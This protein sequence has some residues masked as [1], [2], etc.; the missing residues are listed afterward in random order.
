MNTHRTRIK[1]IC[2]LF[3][4][5]AMIIFRSPL[6]I[7]GIFVVVT[8]ISIIR[9]SRIQVKTRLLSLGV[10][11]ASVIIFQVVCNGSVSMQERLLLGSESALRI[12]T[13]SL[14]VFLFTETTSV[15]EI[16]SA[17]SFLPQKMRLMMTIS[18]SL[19]PVITREIHTIRIAQQAR[20]FQPRGVH[21]VRTVFP[22]I[23]PLLYRT[24][25][26]AEHI[27]MVLETRGFDA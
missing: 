4:S 27:A 24:L 16:M 1:L 20:G 8:F 15:S 19:I 9:S 17:F 18:F 22:I 12:M 6:V 14:L 5:T 3:C 13:L 21:V 23:I 25:A 10:V 2:L 11:S 26:R 7:L